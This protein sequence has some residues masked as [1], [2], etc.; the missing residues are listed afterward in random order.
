MPMR[1]V[2]TRIHGFLDY[3][4]GVLLIALP[5]LFG[6]ADGTA[7]QWVPVILGLGAIGYSLVTDYELGVAPV[8][9]MP[10]HLALDA[11]SGVLLA[12]SPWLFG[13]ADRVWGPH[14]V[15]GLFEVAASLI[16]VTSPVR[17]AASR[18]A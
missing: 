2:P 1:F 8:L 18:S 6:F 4:T 9:S 12:A 3:G 15:V 14:V 16:T 10:T 13:F 11:G 7:A 5:W 17:G